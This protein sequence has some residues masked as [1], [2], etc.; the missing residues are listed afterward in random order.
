MLQIVTLLVLLRCCF[1]EDYAVRESEDYVVRESELFRI[2]L[3]P[4]ND[5]VLQAGSNP[6]A[7]LTQYCSLFNTT[8]STRRCV[9]DNQHKVLSEILAF[10][11]LMKQLD[12]NAG[13]FMNCDEEELIPTYQDS[14]HGE[15]YWEM[16]RLLQSV[17]SSDAEALD[18]FDRRRNEMR[19]NEQDALDL[20]RNAIILHPNST[21]I[22]SQFGLTLRAFGYDHLTEKLWENTV[23]RGLWPS[24]MQRPE[25]YY[26]PMENSKPWQD[27]KDFPFVS[28]LEAGYSTIHHELLANLERQEQITSEDIINRAAVKDNQWKVI[29]LKHPGASNFT[30]SAH[31]FFPETLR[32]LKECDIEFLLAKFSAIVPGTHIKAHT[33]PS[34]DQL[35]AHLGLVHTGGARIRAGNEWRTWREGKVMIFDSSWEHEVH[36]DGPDLRI[37]LILDIWNPYLNNRFAT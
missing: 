2:R 21:Y 31:K 30:E 32:I 22:I 15:F 3:Y 7:Q 17:P 13:L 18:A 36:H 35:R 27:V 12:A 19:M 8:S 16:L 33:G 6:C 9:R 4:G 11:V 34:N 24:T 28:R 20:Y 29:V 23:R 5:L 25:L 14:Q 26:V 1:G 37:V 10:S